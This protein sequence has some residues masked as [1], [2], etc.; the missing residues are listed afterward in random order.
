MPIFC[1]GD[2]IGPQRVN[3]QKLKCSADI[4]ARGQQQQQKQKTTFL[5]SVEKKVVVAELES[6]RPKIRLWIF[7][8][9]LS[10]RN[11]TILWDRLVHTVARFPI[12]D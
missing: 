11:S 10:L 9:L 5:K 4:E 7:D 6:A 2:S 3:C 8:I 1:D 12:I